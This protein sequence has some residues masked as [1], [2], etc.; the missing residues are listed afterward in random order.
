MRYFS[1]YWIWL[2]FVIGLFGCPVPG[3]YWLGSQGYRGQ[4][5]RASPAAQLPLLGLWGVAYFALVVWY[6]HFAHEHFPD[7][8][9][10]PYLGAFGVG[11]AIGVLAVYTK[12]GP[13][14]ETF[15]QPH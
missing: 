10:Y 13:R 1:D 12:L 11:G 5:F 6:A 14:A 3:N 9:P 2:S 7:P 4:F 8:Y 15:S